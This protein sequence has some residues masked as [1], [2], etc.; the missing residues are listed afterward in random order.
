MGLLIG[1]K[2]CLDKHYFNCNLFPHWD[3]D[4][5]YFLMFSEDM[6]LKVLFSYQRSITFTT[7]RFSSLSVS[8]ELQILNVINVILSYDN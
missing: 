6:N 5:H 1:E 7:L 8:N 2:C 3:K 4:C